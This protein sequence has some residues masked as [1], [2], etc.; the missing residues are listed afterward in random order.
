METKEKSC[1]DKNDQKKCNVRW[2]EP[3]SYQDK[4]LFFENDTQYR[5][6]LKE[7]TVALRYITHA[8]TTHTDGT[9]TVT[10]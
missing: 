3:L 7:Y 6:F 5:K 9:V 1:R 4:N 10:I 8:R 2:N